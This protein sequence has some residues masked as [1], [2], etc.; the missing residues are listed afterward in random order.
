[1]PR[2]TSRRAIHTEP[3]QCC[4]QQPQAGLTAG[5]SSLKDVS[6]CD[7]VGACRRHDAANPPLLNRANSCNGPLVHGEDHVDGGFNFY[8]LTVE[9]KRPIAGPGDGIEGGLTKHGRAAD[10]LKMLDAAI[11]GNECLNN[12]CA[13]NMSSSGDDWI[14]GL[15]RR[16]KL[17]RGHPG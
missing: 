2:K 9:E 11:F 13:R 7:R 4:M 15:D 5:T 17:A 8:W 10:G 1:M 3:K 6:T 14:D 12:N 16:E